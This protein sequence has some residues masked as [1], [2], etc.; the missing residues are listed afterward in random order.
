MND[1]TDIL[2]IGS[3]EELSRNTFIRLIKHHQIPFTFLD[4]ET[5]VNQ[6]SDLNSH[7][8]LVVLGN[9]Y[10][11]IR[12]EPYLNG[13]LD[14]LIENFRNN[15]QPVFLEF[16]PFPH[17][18]TSTSQ[19]ILRNPF[20]RVIVR[21]FKSPILKDLLPL[22]LLEAHEVSVLQIDSV[23]ANL[24]DAIEL[25][26]I[27]KVAGVYT[28]TFG[29]PKELLPILLLK[30]SFLL[31]TIKLS[32]FD[33]MEFRLKCHWETLAVN[34][35][36]FLCGSWYIFPESV[37]RLFDSRNYFDAYKNLDLST[38]MTKY[39]ET[40]HQ[41]LNWFI[42]SGVLNGENGEKGVYE[43][44]SSSF[45]SQGR[46]TLRR[47]EFLGHLC[48]RAD[49]T[50]DSAFCFWLGSLLPQDNSV[51]ASSQP[52]WKL[53]GRN[54][55]H[56]LYS[57][58]QHFDND[59]SLRR[60][61][62]GWF[63]D[64][65]NHNVFYSDDN[66]R[67]SLQSILYAYTHQNTPE[68]A[69]LFLRSYAN[70]I[71][72]NQT[73]GKNG[74]RPARIDLK[75]FYPWKGRKGFRRQKFKRHQY[76]SPHYEGWTF[77]AILYGAY[78]LQDKELIKQ[79][80]LGIEDYMQI[81]PRIAVEH[82]TGDDFSK[83]LI[84]CVLLYQCTKESRHL[85]YINQIIDFFAAIQDPTTGAFPER[86]P[87]NMHART[88]PSNEKYGKGES[89]LYTQASD[90]ITDQLYS[91]GFLAWGLYFASKTGQ[92]PQARSMLERFLDYLSAIQIRSPNLQLNGVWTRGFDYYYGEPY[93]AN[94]DVGWG[95]Y[96]LETGWTQGPILTAFAM[97][98]LDFNPFIPLNE[99][100][101]VEIHHIYEKE[102]QYQLAIEKNWKKY[103]P[104][105]QTHPN[106]LSKEALEALR[107]SLS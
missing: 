66:G 82:S 70:V 47:D 31:C 16:Y 27:G 49:C 19:K 95:A 50:A 26:S 103:T 89:A 64:Y 37:H 4:W 79:V 17:S 71:A 9:T 6:Q 53:I 105:P 78:L 94:G 96:S 51:S 38:R 57:Y 45:D 22:T 104:K 7:T 42:Q 24:T 63:N 30:D 92:V 11:I 68:A 18:L 14:Q 102:L 76:Q 87:Y 60:G 67:C 88:E 56:E 32:A 35:I 97:Y 91:A 3:Q 80:Q 73:M 61:F 100:K 46:K 52:R 86:D 44:F 85:T 25:I 8:A 36:R 65:Y 99:A 39:W 83:L 29:L 20:H 15:H 23:A 58:W 84:A 21:D 59:Q 74:H 75:H 10:P 72:L 34:I 55:F 43:G 1:K 48:Q 54:L 90:T 33:D 5:P 101:R 81:F 77:A 28:A 62:F 40:L 98:L 12:L 106:R 93:G 107:K 69:D 13:R 41:G 2:I